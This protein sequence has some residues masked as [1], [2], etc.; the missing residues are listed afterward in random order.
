MQASIE[1]FFDTATATVS[2]DAGRTAYRVT[3]DKLKNGDHAVAL[4]GKLHDAE[5]ARRKKFASRL[6]RAADACIR[7]RGDR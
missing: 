6:D 4:F 5:F 2:Y 3:Y 1:A 7:W